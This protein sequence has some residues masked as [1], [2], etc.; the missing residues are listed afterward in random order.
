MS[1]VKYVSIDSER[2]GQRIDNFLL[3]YFKG[4]PR[5]HV[6]RVLRKGEVRVNKGRVQ[7]TYRLK[8][9]DEV[10]IPPVKM[11]S[12]EINIKVSPALTQV[13]ENSVLYE[14]EALLVINKPSGLAVHGGSSVSCGVIE[15]LRAIRP[16]EKHL[17]LAHRLDKETSG[18]L[19]IAKKRSVLKAL[20]DMFREREVKKVYHA[21]VIGRWPKRVNKINAALERTTL[22]SGDRRVR[23]DEE[24]KESTTTFSIL[25]H[26]DDLSLI[27]AMPQT[28]RTHQI[29]VHTQV[30]GHPIVGDDKYAP[31]AQNQALMAAHDIRR[32]CL[33]AARL[34]FRLPGT[35]KKITVEAPYD[36]AFAEILKRL[37]DAL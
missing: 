37:T 6:Y 19:L 27:E 13:L 2:A 23:M 5:T 9:G 31:K 11:D 4:V 30:A 17:E 33:H 12:R 35:D 7:A 15:A 1:Q 36:K 26:F 32:L 3:T 8:T 34:T 10:R 29:R 21:L 28:G 16:Q 24:G 14:D 18:C 25:K 20:H 22:K